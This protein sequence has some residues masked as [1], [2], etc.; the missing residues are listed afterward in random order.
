MTKGHGQGLM[1]S[2]GPPLE[3]LVG[4]GNWEREK[5]CCS[6]AHSVK[7]PPSPVGRLCTPGGDLNV[8]HPCGTLFPY[9]PAFSSVW[10][11]VRHAKQEKV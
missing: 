11:P 4:V 1:G 5:A 9:S 2:Q 3:G 6:Q 8:T 10:R 7:W